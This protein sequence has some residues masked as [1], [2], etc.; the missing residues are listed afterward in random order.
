MAS[1]RTLKKQIRQVCGD[2][3]GECITASWLIK[4]A[5]RKQLEQCVIKAAQ[6]QMSALQHVNISFDKTPKDFSTKH[7]YKK[8]RKQYYKAAIK[9]FEK[10]FGQKMEEIVNDMNKS[11]PSK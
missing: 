10:G 9:S 4:D 6:L 1:K 2:I 7:E 11:V 3:A 8:A 5:D